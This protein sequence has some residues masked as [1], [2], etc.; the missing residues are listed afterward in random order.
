MAYL[1]GNLRCITSPSSAVGRVPIAYT[2]LPAI[3]ENA[4]IVWW[5]I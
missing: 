1:L 2:Y 4:V 5:P 3:A